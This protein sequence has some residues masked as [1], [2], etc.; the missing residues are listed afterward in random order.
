MDSTGPGLR[1][2]FVNT[3]MNLRVPRK[4]WISWPAELLSRKTLCHVSVSRLVT[5]SV[6]VLWTTGITPLNWCWWVD[7]F[8]SPTDYWTWFWLIP[9]PPMKKSIIPER[10]CSLL[11]A[12]YTFLPPPPSIAARFFYFCESSFV[13]TS[14]HSSTFPPLFCSS[15]SPIL[16]SAVLLSF[17]QS[18][19]FFLF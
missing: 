6:K 5:A 11:A 1:P 8:V 9:I 13:Y 4:Q 17:I 7:T 16:H 14:R 19:L 18:F 12:H 3:V 2:S 15:S 10:P